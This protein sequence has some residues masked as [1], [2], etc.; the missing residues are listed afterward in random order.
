MLNT[1]T[2]QDQLPKLNG[3]R[4]FI[5]CTQ[6]NDYQQ[7]CATQQLESAFSA[8]LSKPVGVAGARERR[9]RRK[10]HERGWPEDSDDDRLE[11]GEH[12]GDGCGR[13]DS[14]EL[15]AVSAS[16]F[17]KMATEFAS[18]NSSRT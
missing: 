3:P 1:F 11:V 10:R 5:L 15:P 4:S 13:E 8:R 14:V 12:D 6:S 7:A 16:Y 18:H 17:S 2:V 9:Q